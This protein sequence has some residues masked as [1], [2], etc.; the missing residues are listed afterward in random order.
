MTANKQLVTTLMWDK[1][2]VLVGKGYIVLRDI[3]MDFEYYHGDKFVAHTIYIRL[4]VYI[5]RP[6]DVCIILKCT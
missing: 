3:G 1:V 6:T 4:I 5:R 2:L